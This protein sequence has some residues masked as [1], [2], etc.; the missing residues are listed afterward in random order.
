MARPL[1]DGLDYFP[2]DTDASS[3][4]KIEGLR[5]LFGNDAYAFFFITLERIY[6]TNTGELFLGDDERKVLAK[7]IGISLRKFE[8]ILQNC[9]KKH[10]FNEIKFQNNSCL[11]SE[12]IQKRFVQIQAERARKRE[13]YQNKKGVLDGKNRGRNEGET[14]GEMG[15]ETPQSKEKKSIYIELAFRL[16][17]PI[18]DSS[19]FSIIGKYQ[20]ELG[21]KELES[22]LAR[23]VAND[24]HFD[25][26]NKLAAYLE[27]C[28]KKNGE[29]N[30]TDGLKILSGEEPSWL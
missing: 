18:K 3:D 26:E 29:I 1:K 27:T 20:K 13:Y 10:L 5:V 22:I 7:K 28:K 9:L 16:V 25:N 24:K 12:G 8:A 11:T 14:P 17:K 4:E 2:H 23:C 15:G 19:L 21:E 6:R 30:L